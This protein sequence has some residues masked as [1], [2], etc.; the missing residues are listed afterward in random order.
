MLGVS[1][2]LITSIQHAYSIIPAPALDASLGVVL[3]TSPLFAGAFGRILGYLGL[4]FGA[5][6]LVLGFIGTFTP[7]QQAVDNVL[8]GQQ[9]WLIAIT[10]VLAF[11][12]TARAGSRVASPASPRAAVLA[13]E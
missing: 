2:N 13:A 7:L 1:L 9:V 6:L 4:A 11:S 3:L 12:A 5:V 10:V 8:T